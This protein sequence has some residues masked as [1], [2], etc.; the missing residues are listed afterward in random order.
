[1]LKRWYRE[2]AGL[3]FHGQ[4]TA[5]VERLS[6]APVVPPFRLRFMKKRWGSCSAKGTLSLN[7]HMI[8]APE[9][10]VEYVLLHELCHLRQHN[11]SKRFYALLELHMPDWRERKARLEDMAE[12]IFNE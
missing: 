11:H 4:L 1:M 8:K 12:M 6:W 9:E 3:Y 10:C 2:R 5:L 7:T